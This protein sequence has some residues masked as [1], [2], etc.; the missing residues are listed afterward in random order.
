VSVEANRRAL[1]PRYAQAGFTVPWAVFGLT[2][3][4]AEQGEWA[5]DAAL[6]ILAGASPREIG[7]SP[8]S[9]H[10]AA[11]SR[12]TG[13]PTPCWI[14]GTAICPCVR[15][16]TSCAS[17]TSARRNRPESSRLE[18]CS[19]VGACDRPLCRSTGTP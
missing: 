18:L 10:I 11:F 16:I 8:D 4:A 12:S 14:T 19:F 2:K 5:A 6:R 7:W 1:D 9:I 15:A 17:W 13:T 3:V